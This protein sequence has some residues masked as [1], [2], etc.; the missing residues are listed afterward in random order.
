MPNL[1]VSTAVD[2]LM[3][4]A[5]NAAFRTQLGSTTTGDALFTAADASAGRTTL[6]A[7][8]T[9]AAVFTA[10]DASAARITLGA[11][12]TG[13]AI[14]RATN[15]A[16]LDA[17]MGITTLKKL[18]DTAL[19]SSA[20]VTVPDFTFA[21]VSGVTYR[22]WGELILQSV[23]TTV[24]FKSE[25]N[26]PAIDSLSSQFIGW[27]IQPNGSVN[28]VGFLSTTRASWITAYTG[29]A[30]F[31]RMAFDVTLRFSA[32]GNVT[33]VAAQNSTDAANPSLVKER[34]FLKYQI[35]DC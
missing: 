1:T 11:G 19:T 27:M 23:V 30:R 32:A 2:E 26:F 4:S 15:I 8:A 25:L 31:S 17:A 35:I 20:F 21:V 3:Q 5:D 18:A 34:S 9:G 6:G 10:A 24:G 29:A 7:T 28:G 13:D 14:F 22:I 33:I 16:Q 12:T